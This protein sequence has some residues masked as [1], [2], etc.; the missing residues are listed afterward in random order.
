MVKALFI[1]VLFFRF[2]FAQEFELSDA[3]ATKDELL[4]EKIRSFLDEKSFVQN[5]A[6]IDIV[7]DPKS[8][9]FENEQLNSIKIVETLKENGLL[10]LFFDAPQEFELNFRTS[11]SPLFFIKI[12]RDTLR[13]IGYYR[14]VTTASHLDSSEFYWS[15]SLQS[16][17][18]TD[19]LVLQNQL[20]KSGCKI[21]DVQRESSNKW[22]YTIDMSHGYLN[23]PKLHA[24]ENFDLKRSLY[25]HWLDVSDIS[26]LK[27][28]S[29][30]Q[31][32]WYPYIAYYNSS[33]HLLKII[34]ED[35]IHK[36]I[37]LDIPKNAKYMKI[38]DLYSL[39]NVKNELHLFPK[40]RE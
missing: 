26:Y 3:N 1:I 4:L 8:A 20:A 21:M 24:D 13:S 40:N 17:Y 35:R 22:A 16:E 23:L 30:R 5:R 7:F 9:Y 18:A 28:T 25:A 32:H 27:I 33:M 31:N 10:K 19:P 6:F 36:S 39:K 15:I 38:S 29:S 11:G 2:A 12:M 14:Y 37:E 34:K